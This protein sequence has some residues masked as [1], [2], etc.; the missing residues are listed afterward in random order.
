MCPTEDCCSEIPAAQR[1]EPRTS[2]CN[3]ETKILLNNFNGNKKTKSSK[4]LLCSE[5]LDPSPTAKVV[6]VSSWHSP[7]VLSSSSSHNRSFCT[8][9][10]EM[11]AGALMTVLSACSGSLTLGIPRRL[12]FYISTAL[13]AVFGLKML[14][15]GYHIVQHS[16]KRDAPSEL[17]PTW[18]T[19]R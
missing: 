11:S 3:I 17:S 4:F 19:K 13:F 10:G 9:T 18:W 8:L 14:H 7:R 12:A 1:M 5:L 15:E 2:H 6:A 16:T